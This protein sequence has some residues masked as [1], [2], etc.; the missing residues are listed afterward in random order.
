MMVIFLLELM[1]CCCFSPYHVISMGRCITARVH[2]SCE[3]T[4]ELRMIIYRLIG[5]RVQRYMQD[6]RIWAWNCLSIMGYRHL[7]AQ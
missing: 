6:L 4:I 3:V 2:D 7:G 1:G 5:Y